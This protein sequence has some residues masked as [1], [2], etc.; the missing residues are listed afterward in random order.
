[1]QGSCVYFRRLSG[2]SRFLIVVGC[3]F[4]I[5][6]SLAGAREKKSLVSAASQKR[7]GDAQLDASTA[8]TNYG[9]ATSLNVAA[10][11]NTGQASRAVVQFDLSSFPNIGVKQ[12][13]LG[14]T[15][16]SV[17]SKTGSYEVHR[18]TNL[19]QESAVTWTNRVTG[20]AWTTVGGDFNAT[21]TAATT[22]NGNSAVPATYTWGITADVQSWYG[23]AQNFGHVILENPLAGNDINGILF[24]S[25]EAAAS[26]PTLALTYL[27]QVSNLTAT[28]GNSTVTLTWTNPT[29]MTGATSLEGYAGVLILR[30]VDKPV[31]ATSVPADGTT[32]TAC[33]TIGAGSDVV[34]F[35]NSTSATTFTDSGLCGGLTNDHTYSYKVFA[36]DT[37]HNYSTECSTATS[38]SG[39]CSANAS[40][41][42]PEVVAIPSATVSAQA[43]WVFNTLATSSSAPGI[44]PGTSAVTGSNTLLFDIDPQTGLQ[45]VPPVSLGGTISSR[46]TL[47]DTA[48]DSIAQNVAY[49]PGQD[50]FVYAVNTDT[51]VLDWL[52]N[53]ASA[54]FV[55]SAGLQAKLFSG[56]TYTLAKDLVV[57]GTHN[58][59]TTSGNKFV[60]LNANT[61]ATVW[62]VTGNVGGVPALDI[63]N[64]APSIDYTHSA[65][66]FA[67]R[68]NGGTAQPSLWKLNPNTGAVL[69]SASLGPIDY[70][71]TLAPLSDI[72]FV[73]VNGGSLLAIDPTSGATLASVNPGDGGLKSSAAVATNAL[74]YTV[75]FSTST[76][77][78]AYQFACVPTPNVCLP[79]LGGAFTLVWGGTAITTPSAPLTY[80]PLTKA[81]VGG[82]DGKIHELDLATGVDGKQRVLN[83]SGGVTVGDVSI[84]T[85]LSY[86]IASATDGRVYAFRFPF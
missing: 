36:V 77:V 79:G 24:N 26:T 10:K 65:I 73:S 60:A 84:D 75:V 86:V 54:P 59:T 40:S 61:G 7:G 23:G 8:S 69:F 52:V 42:V 2:F 5:L 83:S 22:I 46:P 31:S 68:S 51:G 39:A 76:K 17:G 48:D 81:Y 44:N 20:T 9:S 12:A 15:I 14:I 66:W 72:L 64:A 30:Q 49:I 37:A 85:T 47:I 1:M 50:N 35:V 63:V 21:S 53:P 29:T 62:T 19:W 38:G 27:Q 33:G 28:A 43:V 25:R 41:I 78:W 16:T 55:A 80:Y 11:G 3:L 82:G 58:G 18:V 70:S 45:I 6:A 34:V 57:A 13:D 32:Y 74:P 56:A 71:P 67:S 4:G